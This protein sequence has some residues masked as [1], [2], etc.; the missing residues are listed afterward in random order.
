[1]YWKIRKGLYPSVGAL[2]QTGTTVI[3]EDVTFPVSRMAEAT[4]ALQG[5]FVKYNYNE[6]VIFGHALEG[7][8]HFVFNQDLNSQAEVDRYE[9]FMDELAVLV[10]DRFDGSLKAEHGTGRNMAPYVEKQWAK[11]HLIL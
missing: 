2:R 3:I 5:L 11:K 9:K 4:T 8:I 10:V 1:M 6:A 7:N